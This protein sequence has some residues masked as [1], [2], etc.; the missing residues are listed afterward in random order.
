MGLEVEVAHR[1]DTVAASSHRKLTQTGARLI[2]TSTI[3]SFVSSQDLTKSHN[4][5]FLSPQ[6]VHGKDAVRQ[7]VRERFRFLSPQ[8]HEDD[9]AALVLGRTVDERSAMELCLISLARFSICGSTTY[10]ISLSVMFCAFSVPNP[11]KITGTSSF[12]S[13]MYKQFC[14]L[15]VFCP[16]GSQ[17][18][19]FRGI[20]MGC[21]RGRKGW[22]LSLV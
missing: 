20:L 15:E 17:C 21:E 16:A 10:R 9:W 19:P 18:I 3:C 5:S 1:F 4:T 12:R 11:G 7:F 13:T 22:R 14:S 2:D 8:P 6:N